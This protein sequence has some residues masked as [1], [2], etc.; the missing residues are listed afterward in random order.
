MGGLRSFI[1]GRGMSEYQSEKMDRQKSAETIVPKMS[2][3]RQKEGRVESLEQGSG[4]A[5]SKS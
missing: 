3:E 5:G 1:R 2:A 4:R